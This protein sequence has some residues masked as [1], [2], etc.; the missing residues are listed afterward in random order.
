MTNTFMTSELENCILDELIND[1][2]VRCYIR[3]VDH[4]LLLVKLEDIDKI[5]NSIHLIKI[6]S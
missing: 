3:H 6:F 1:D 5:F 4:T 2:S